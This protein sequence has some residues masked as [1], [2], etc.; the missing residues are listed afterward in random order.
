MCEA[1]IQQYPQL[2]LSELCVPVD[3]SVERVN[4]FQECAVCYAVILVITNL[5]LGCTFFT[6]VRLGWG[7]GVS[8]QPADISDLSRT[9]GNQMHSHVIHAFPYS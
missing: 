8:S 5:L 4:I 2:S 3:S 9:R 1:V 7:G 6:G